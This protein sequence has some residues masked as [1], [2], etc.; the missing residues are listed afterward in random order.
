MSCC[1]T[2]GAFHSEV[3]LV[4]EHC[5]FDHVHDERR[6]QSNVGWRQV[7]ESACISR[8]FVID[9]SAP[10]SVCGIDKFQGVEYVCCPLPKVVPGQ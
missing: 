1:H 6:C 9:S 2:V 10:L 8:G 7:A 4:P 3:L 5:V